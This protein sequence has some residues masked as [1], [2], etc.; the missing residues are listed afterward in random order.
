[1]S[2][3][4]LVIVSK[5]TTTG[6][7]REALADALDRVSRGELA[8]TD[9]VVMIGLANQITHSMAVELKHQALENALG[10]KTVAFGSIN[11][12]G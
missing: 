7:V 9:G 4:E 6:K 3:T 1:M 8:A 5:I 11:I 10:H 2:E 12:G